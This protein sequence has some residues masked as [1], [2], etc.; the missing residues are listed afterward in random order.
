[1]VQPFQVVEFNIDFTKN[2]KKQVHHFHTSQGFDIYRQCPTCS[3]IRKARVTLTTSPFR[4]RLTQATTHARIRTSFNVKS[5]LFLF[6]VDFALALP[7]FLPAFRSPLP[8]IGVT[9]ISTLSFSCRLKLW[10]EKKERRWNFF[11]GS[12]RGFHKVRC[13]LGTVLLQ[14]YR[15]H[16]C[17]RVEFIV[18]VGQVHLS[19]SSAPMWDHNVPN[20]VIQ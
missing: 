4:I 18:V 17:T 13:V 12:F 14:T 10:Q 15:W 6:S 8:V 1:M 3:E 11:H 19:V 2:E 5:L 7:V 9:S 20:W 16:L